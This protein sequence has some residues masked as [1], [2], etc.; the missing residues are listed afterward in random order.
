MLLF[1]R[2][3]GYRNLNQEEDPRIKILN[4]Y[5]NIFHKKDVLDIGCN[6]GHITLTVARDFNANSVVG[7]DI[8]KH[9]IKVSEELFNFNL[10]A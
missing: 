8:D 2:Y 5:R 4:K 3:Y 7:L 6:I 1:F 10:Q 9:L